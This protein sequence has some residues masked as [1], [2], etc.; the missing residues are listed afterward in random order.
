MKR[1]RLTRLTAAGFGLFFLATLEFGCLP[2]DSDDESAADPP[3]VLEEQASQ[4]S[5]PAPARA[6]AAPDFDRDT[7]PD[8]RD[9]CSFAPNPDQADIDGDGVGDACDSCRAIPNAAQ[10]D[11]DGDGFGDACDNCP[12]TDNVNQADS[13]GDGIGDACDNCRNA[14]NADQ[15]D[16]DG[17]GL[18][19]ACDN[20]PNSPNPDQSDADGDGLGD[21]CDVTGAWRLTS[22]VGLGFDDVPS[23]FLDC[24]ADGTAHIVLEQLQT[25]LRRCEDVFVIKSTNGFV[26]FDSED[27][28]FARPDATTLELIDTQERISTFTLVD[29]IPP[30]SD[31]RTFTVVNRFDEGIEQPVLFEGGMAFAATRL[32]YTSNPASGLPH[33]IS[34]NPETG[35]HGTPIEFEPGE[36]VFQ[37]QAAQGGEFWTADDA[38]A[39]RQAPNGPVTDFVA[40]QVLGVRPELRA[41]AFDP[42]NLRLI[43]L[44]FNRDESRNELI[45]VFLGITPHFVVTRVPCDISGVSSMT[46]DGSSLWMIANSVIARVNPFTGQVLDSFESPDR[47]F[48][49]TGIAADLSQPRLFLLG[50]RFDG[51]EGTSL[52]EVAR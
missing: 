19:D 42:A 12:S 11:S 44:N 21:A 34:L 8:E 33:I 1:D 45:Q 13:D 39:T 48:F 26:R 41:L 27:F 9:N 25:R 4:P 32:F 40:Q 38:I 30:E 35:V 43:L 52:I 16:S 3:A 24:R 17:D 23:S 5:P 50:V 46:W 15:A 6:P 2:R 7:V 47:D 49:F 22:G 31:C 10:T 29:Q 51:G 18:G 28:R 37:I 36:P 14:A 20:C